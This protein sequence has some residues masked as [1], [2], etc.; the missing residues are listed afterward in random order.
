MRELKHHEKKL[1]KKVNFYDWKDERTI[2]QN[3]ILARYHTP[4]E[5][6]EKYNKMCGQVTRCVAQLRKLDPKD[7]DRIKMTEVLLEKLYSMGVI[8]T[9][10]NL[11][12]CAELHSSAFMKRRLSTVLRNLH[13]TQDL[14]T[15][16]QYIKQGHVRIGPEVVTNPAMHITREMEDHITWSEGSKIKRHVREFN[17]EMD[18]FDM[19]NV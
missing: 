12:Q 6:Y 11:E 19:L 17:D 13:F 4:R 10:Q 3:G 14:T 7:E 15:A 8:S 1:L 18:D 2:R 16:V 9:K 5:D